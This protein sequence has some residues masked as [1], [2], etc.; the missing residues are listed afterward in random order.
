MWG[1]QFSDRWAEYELRLSSLLRW[2]YKDKQV[3]SVVWANCD[4]FGLAWRQ[5]RSSSLV[6]YGWRTN[7]VGIMN[8]FFTLKRQSNN[9]DS[10]EETRLHRSDGFLGSVVNAG[11]F[12]GNKGHCGSISW[13]QVEPGVGD[14]T[15]DGRLSPPPCVTQI[16]EAGEGR[17]AWCLRAAAVFLFAPMNPTPIRHFGGSP[18]SYAAPAVSR[19]GG[20]WL[21]SSAPRG[22]SAATSVDPYL[23]EGDMH[24][25]AFQR[26][27]AEWIGET[28]LNQGL[29][30][31]ACSDALIATAGYFPLL[32]FCVSWERLSERLMATS[33]GNGLQKHISHLHFGITN[34]PPKQNSFMGSSVELETRHSALKPC[35]SANTWQPFGIIKTGHAPQPPLFTVPSYP[36]PPH[37]PWQQYPL[38]RCFFHFSCQSHLLHH[39]PGMALIENA[40]KCWCGARAGCL[41]AD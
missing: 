23:S 13:P 32:L 4:H 37:A 16:A 21:C 22:R 27:F 10:R 1:M 14:L 20:D 11:L 8:T 25:V 18:G 31:W 17:A 2:T 38:R 28:H 30:L 34:L 40:L 41:Y 3:H 36:P 19:P 35:Q 12:C 15:C 39:L 7:N 6:C 9:T 29:K 24:T 33:T 26:G 5:R